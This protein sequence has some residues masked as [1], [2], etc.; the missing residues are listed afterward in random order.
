MIQVKNK[1]NCCGCSACSNICPQHCICMKFDKEGFL[2]PEVDEKRCINCNLCVKV[3]PVLN[4]V[5]GQQK[6]PRCFVAYAKDDTLRMN[7]SS[8]GIFGVLAQYVLSCGGTVFGA[9]FDQNLSVVHM[10]ID[11]IEQLHKLQGSKY[12][13]SRILDSYI[14]VKKLLLNDKMVLFSGTECQIAGLR[15]YLGGAKYPNLITLDVLCHGVPS[16][17]VMEKY[18]QWQEKENNSKITEAHFRDKTW[19]WKNYSIRL[20]FSNHKVYQCRAAQDC[21]MNLFLSDICLRPSCYTCHFKGYNRLSDLTLGDA[22]GIENHSPEMD[23][24][25]GTSV[26]LIHTEKGNQLLSL[27]EKQICIKKVDLAQAIP[28]NAESIQS[29]VPHMN[30]SL[31]FAKLNEGADLPDLIKLEKLSLVQRIL[32]KVRKQMIGPVSRIVHKQVPAK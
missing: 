13:Q 9:G 26:I 8:G 25:K 17:K 30:R 5:S 27:I 21:Y 32:R 18:F 24:G 4:H 23:D 31:F 16:P 6:N 14:Q 28:M 11:S 19:G 22:W 3:C 7:S 1:E 2:Y 10:R 20:N 29:A 15:S 12:V